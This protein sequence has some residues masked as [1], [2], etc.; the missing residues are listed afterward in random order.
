MKNTY[1]IAFSLFSLALLSCS[2]NSPSHEEMKNRQSEYETIK[3]ELDGTKGQL[4]SEK[5]EE[6]FTIVNQY[7]TI[8]DT[9][10]K[11]S[12]LNED[13]NY[14]LDTTLI[15]VPT[16][17]NAGAIANNQNS[18]GYIQ[19]QREDDKDKGLPEVLDILKTC[20]DTQD[21]NPCLSIPDHAISNFLQIKYVFISELLLDIAPKMEGTLRTAENFENGLMAEH[22]TCYE[23]GKETPFY[24][25]ITTATNSESVYLTEGS[26]LSTLRSDLKMNYIKKVLESR[27]KHFN[28]LSE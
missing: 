14:K 11:N 12:A 22:T 2:E 20:K 24:S 10:N 25:Y 9:T 4:F 21:D 19:I 16:K 15:T 6:L 17:L 13:E 18:Y 7:E 26:E 28:I 27:N 8:L 23:L 3:T 5:R 1:K